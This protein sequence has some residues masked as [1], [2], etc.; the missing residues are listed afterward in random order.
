MTAAGS[1]TALAKRDE[2]D[3]AEEQRGVCAWLRGAQR[4]D[5]AV[6]E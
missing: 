5:R 1:E 2:H 3:E 6:A 4:V